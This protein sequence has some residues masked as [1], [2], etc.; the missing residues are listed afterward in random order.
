MNRKWDQ[1]K[2]SAGPENGSESIGLTAKEAYQS[3]GSPE[4]GVSPP[5]KA[6]TRQYLLQYLAPCAIP[7]VLMILITP[8]VDPTASTDL[9]T[10][11]KAA[12]GAAADRLGSAVTD[13][14]GAADRWTSS[15][16]TA[17]PANEAEEEESIDEMIAQP[18]EENISSPV[19]SSEDE[20][21]GEAGAD[22]Y[23]ADAEAEAE[24]VTDDSAADEDVEVEIT[25]A[26]LVEAEALSTGDSMDVAELSGGRWDTQLHS[27]VNPTCAK[28]YETR[29]YDGS[30]RLRTGFVSYPRSGNSYMRS[31]VERATGFQTSSVYCD[32]SLEKTFHAECDHRTN[33]FVKTHFPSLGGDKKLDPSK[34]Y[35]QFDQV[36][37]V[38]RNPLDAI[39]SWWQL[40]AAKSSLAMS[41]PLR[42]AAKVADKVFGL[43]D[44]RD[45]IRY[46]D[47]WDH[48]THYWSSVPV[49]RHTLRYE[50][51]KAQPVPN[52]MA[53]LAFVMPQDD[54]PGLDKLACLGEKDDGHEAYHSRRSSDFA[55]WD[56][57]EP[58]L[59]R[60]LLRRVR[61]SFCSLGYDKLLVK[62]RPDAT[63]EMNGFCES[64]EWEGR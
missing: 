42:H 14:K 13:V 7:V 30:S 31:L 20:E 26:E 53:L 3:I 32:P 4:P 38:V 17:A 1:P 41:D 56:A 61:T 29:L 21:D 27:A 18:D 36:V 19:L 49:H 22:V 6:G 35:R 33:F 2:R 57:F 46:I 5:K 52:M 58:S 37:H 9:T 15:S 47:R 44:R 54:L 43:A 16:G 10:G 12:Y 39:A 64:V 50:D 48:H 59:R 8:F 40:N 28:E 25:E 60:T 55:S 34:Y 63:E 23:E 51:L 45:M 11:A 24:V 62:A